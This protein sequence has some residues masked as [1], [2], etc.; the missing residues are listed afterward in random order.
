MPT[1]IHDADGLISS[2]AQQYGRAASA[3]AMTSAELVRFDSVVTPVDSATDAATALIRLAHGYF[4]DSHT[5]NALTPRERYLACIKAQVPRGS[6]AIIAEEAA[7][8]LHGLPV[9]LRGVRIAIANTSKRVRPPRVVGPNQLPFRP[10][11]LVKRLNTRIRPSDVMEIDG[12]CVTDV[13]KSVIDI[14]RSAESE[15]GLIVADAA[16]RSQCSKKELNQVLRDYPRAPGNKKARKLLE[17]ANDRS[18]SV[19]ESITKACIIDAGIAVMPAQAH[20]SRSGLA[21][22]TASRFG[23]DTSRIAHWAGAFTKNGVPCGTLFQQVEFRNHERFL[24]R[25]DFFIPELNLVIEFDGR[26]KYSG[27]GAQATE[28]VMIKEREREQ[29]L[30]NIGLDVHRLCWKDVINGDCLDSLQRLAHAQ[31]RRISAGGR[32][33]TSSDGSCREAEISSN[34]RHAR[35]RLIDNRT[36]RRESKLRSLGEQ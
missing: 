26:V 30:R 23:A 15:N 13:P 27:N 31:Y 21:K 25:V 24:G 7:A 19:G 4:L 6:A 33:F 11:E 29:H 5:W 9:L 22:N 35:Q 20:E 10:N 18:E 17:I 8:A 1:W 3:Y 28:N 36:A 32:I 2:A 14:C 12:R 34:I 16:L